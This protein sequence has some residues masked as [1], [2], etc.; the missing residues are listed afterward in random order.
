MK[1]SDL[2]WIIPNSVEILYILLNS[3]SVFWIH[4]SSLNPSN[5]VEFV[6]L[7]E[8]FRIHL[9]SQSLLGFTGFTSILWFLSDFLEIFRINLNS[10]NLFWI[11]SKYSDLTWIL[12]NFLEIVYILLNSRKIFWIH[13]SSLNPTNSVEIVDLLE[14]FSII[15]SNSLEF[16]RLYL[17]SWNSFKFTLILWIHLNSMSSLEFFEL[18][19]MLSHSFKFFWIH[20]VLF[21]I[22]GNLLILFK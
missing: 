6:E 15:I 8:L 17:N 9:K 16:L 5:S 10:L 14:F 18:T 1:S 19:S 12:W 2:T 7:L 21:W 3:F 4:L 22:I 20:S 13:L 11:L